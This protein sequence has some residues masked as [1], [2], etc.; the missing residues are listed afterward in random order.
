MNGPHADLIQSYALR[1]PKVILGCG[2]DASADIW[3]LGCLVSPLYSTKI[4][5]DGF[6]PF[7]FSNSSPVPG[8]LSRRQ[9][10]LGRRKIITLQTCLAYLAKSSTLRI[11]GV[12]STSNNISA[13]MVSIW[14]FLQGEAFDAIQVG[15]YAFGLM[16]FVISKQLFAITMSW[17]RLNYHFAS[18]FYGRCY[19]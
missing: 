14:I 2:W 9:E 16:R 10:Q 4:D 6:I 13:T 15:Y 19:A 5:A 12:E 18:R 3:N 11:Y 17:T 8:F 7:R 1:A